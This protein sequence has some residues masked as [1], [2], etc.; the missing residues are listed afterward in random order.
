MLTSSLDCRFS[1]RL[2]VG[3]LSEM[4]YTLFDKVVLADLG[5][6]IFRQVLVAKRQ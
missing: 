3:G 2:G 6:Q 4:R 5:H 1:S